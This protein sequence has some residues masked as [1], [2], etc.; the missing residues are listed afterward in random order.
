M[1][2]ESS[3]TCSQSSGAEEYNDKTFAE[4]RR[5]ELLAW[6]FRSEID[7]KL[8]LGMID[9]NIELGIEPKV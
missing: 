8:L 3:P 7:R 9:R 4:N 1:I 6:K 2:D 5:E